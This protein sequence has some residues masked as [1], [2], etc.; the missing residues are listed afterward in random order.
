M[1]RL[2]LIRVAL[3]QSLDNPLSDGA[4][5]VSVRIP[6]RKT[7]VFS[8]SADDP[9]R[10]LIH[11]RII[12]FFQGIFVLRLHITTAN[13]D[14][15]Q[16]IGTDTPEKDLLAACLGVENP[17]FRFVHKRDRKWPILLANRNDGALGILRV[18]DDLIFFT[19]SY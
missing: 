12:V 1:I 8:G 11:L 14:G 2:A 18:D 15:V 4:P 6:P 19:G 9:L 7:V 13:L 5:D 10:V 16:F 3:L 17:L